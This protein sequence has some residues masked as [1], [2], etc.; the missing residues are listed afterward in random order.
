MT[1]FIGRQRCLDRDPDRFLIGMEYPYENLEWV[2][3]EMLINIEAKSSVALLH[4]RNIK[5]RIRRHFVIL[6]RR[7]VKW[8][9]SN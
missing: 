2:T 6:R 7:S 1:D 3:H 4:H 8:N 5:S 9:S